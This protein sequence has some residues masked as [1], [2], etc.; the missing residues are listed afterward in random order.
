[1]VLK[2]SLERS[3]GLKVGYFTYDNLRNIS[4]LVSNVVRLYSIS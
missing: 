4:C 1:M 2:Y 3:M